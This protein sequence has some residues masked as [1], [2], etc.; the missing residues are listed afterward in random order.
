MFNIEEFSK[1]VG[2]KLYFYTTAIKRLY[3]YTP[4]HSHIFI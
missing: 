1:V 4:T 2:Y 3:T